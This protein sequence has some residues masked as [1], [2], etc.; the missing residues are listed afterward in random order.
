[1]QGQLDTVK[2][3]G[4]EIVQVCPLVLKVVG[5]E[6]EVWKLD[7]TVSVGDP[8]GDSPRPL[9]CDTGVA[10]IW[11]GVALSISNASLALL[12][13][14]DGTWLRRVQGQSVTVSVVGDET[15]H[16]FPLVLNVVGV[17]IVVKKLDTTV[18]VGVP[19]GVG[20]TFAASRDSEDPMLDATLSEAEPDP[21]VPL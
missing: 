21:F 14:S 3:V 19:G 13:G 4:D 7:T 10:L 20:P 5:V 1:M 18:S 11:L 17:L 8:R 9:F 2:V 12:Y 15:V 6:N 16:V